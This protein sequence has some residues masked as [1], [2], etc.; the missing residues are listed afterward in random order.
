MGNL[1]DSI[2][3]AKRNNHRK[4]ILLNSDIKKVFKR[5]YSLNRYKRYSALKV[6]QPQNVCKHICNKS[7]LT[8]FDTYHIFNSSWTEFKHCKKITN[9]INK[10]LI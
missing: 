9:F 1:N 10:N 4:P 5:L 8:K 7:I 6:L 2:I 3:Q